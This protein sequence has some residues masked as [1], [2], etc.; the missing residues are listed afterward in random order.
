[1]ES[2]AN[3]TLGNNTGLASE[4]RFV[5][6][7][8]DNT[9]SPDNSLACCDDHRQ[10]LHRVQWVVLRMDCYI[11]PSFFL[12]PVYQEELDRMSPRKDAVFYIRCWPSSWAWAWVW[13]GAACTLS[14]NLCSIFSLFVWSY[15]IFF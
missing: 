14:K 13:M 10:F 3:V 4:H 9:A 12:N 6:I 8:L 2:Y 15:L 5:Y 11:A 7:T 1:V